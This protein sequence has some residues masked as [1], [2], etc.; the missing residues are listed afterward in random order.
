MSLDILTFGEALVEVMRTGLDQPLDRPGLFTGPYPSGAPFIFAV[1]AARLQAQTAAIGVVG[2]DAFGKCLTDQLAADHV[3]MRGIHVREGY[4]TGV[5]FVGY[6][7]DGS[8]DFV[9]HLR[10]AAAGQLAP[11]LL[12]PELFDGLKVLH[13]MGSTLSI[14]AEALAT[15]LK[16]LE[17]AQQAGAKIS[18]DPNLRPQ[19]MPPAQAR[20]AFAPFVAAADVILPTAEEAQLLTGT[21]SLDEAVA[22]LLAGRPTRVIV[23]TQGGQGCQV[24][25]ADGTTHVPGFTVEEVDPTGAGDCFDAGFLVRWQQGYSPVEAARFANGCGALA[26]TAQGPMAGIRSLPEVEAFIQTQTHHA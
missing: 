8:R 3:D 12:K 1:Q 18:F 24:Y 6:S 14:H 9:F 17:L 2:N 13:L 21:A 11:D 19:L 16:A 22:A 7:S 25:T 26:V 10:H 5:A 20:E 15:G 23:I 4:T